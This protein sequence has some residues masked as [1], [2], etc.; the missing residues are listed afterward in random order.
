MSPLFWIIASTFVISL[1]S[2]VG[3]LTLV[4]KEKWLDK[5]LLSLVA[6]AS[7]A[8]MGGAFFHLLPEAIEKLDGERVFVW[9][10]VA[11]VVFL[12]VEKFFQWRHCHKDHCEIHSFGYM[13]LIG[14]GL[15]NF[16]DGLIIAAAFMESVTLG[17]TVSLAVVLHEIPQEFGD[18]GALISAGFKKKRALLVNFFA[19]LTAIA[20]GVVGFFLAGYSREFI[21]ILVPFAA[22]SFIYIAASDLLPEFRKE[23]KTKESVISLLMFLAGIGI[24]YLM[25]FIGTE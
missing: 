9:V 20:G 13:T 3:V 2:F 25:K 17:L 16:I 6:L 24:V 8:L 21:K 23:T 10:L 15:H 12:V 19:A 14:D 1:L 7:G 11:I 5:I 18:F 4:L 22:G